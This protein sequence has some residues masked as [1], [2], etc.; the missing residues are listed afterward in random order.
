MLIVSVIPNSPAERA[1][2]KKGDKILE[3]DGQLTASMNSDKAADLL[4]GAEGTTATLVVQ[5]EQQAARR[6]LVRREQR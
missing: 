3:V 1:G 5:N 6:L 4:Q 2:L